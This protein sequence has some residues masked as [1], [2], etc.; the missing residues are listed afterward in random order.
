MKKGES[1]MPKHHYGKIVLLALCAGL[2]GGMVSSQFFFGRSVFAEKKPPHETVVRAEL[3]ELV[4][5]DGNLRG[6]LAAAQG[7][8]TL[9]LAG[10]RSTF[11]NGFL[12][13]N[14]ASIEL[15]SYAKGK[16]NILVDKEG[17]QLRLFDQLEPPRI[18]AV[19]GNATLKNEDSGRI[20]DRAASSL[21]LFDE[22][23]K[24]IWKVP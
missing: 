1:N 24:V 5:E 6:S 16:I 2:I 14:A 19:L 9:R 11:L 23:G 20:E 8:V 18:R 13:R 21:V 4:D 3:F 12:G 17:L 10:K 15:G 7:A 22:S